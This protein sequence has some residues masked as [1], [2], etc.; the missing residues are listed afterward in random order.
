MCGVNAHLPFVETAV[1]NSNGIRCMTL[2]ENA[3]GAHRPRQGA[4]F[5]EGTRGSL[6]NVWVYGVTGIWMLAVL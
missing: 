2:F 3:G 4:D 6:G 1:E 5:D